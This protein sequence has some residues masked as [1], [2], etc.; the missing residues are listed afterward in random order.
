MRGIKHDDEPRRYE[1]ADKGFRVYHTE[2][3]TMA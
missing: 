1:I 2:P 3:V